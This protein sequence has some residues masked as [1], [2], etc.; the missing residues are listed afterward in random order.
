MAMF[1]TR[2]IAALKTSIEFLQKHIKIPDDKTLYFSEN[3]SFKLK[4][5]SIQMKVVEWKFRLL[6]IFIS[7]FQALVYTC[8]Q[9][10]V[11]NNY[12]FVKIF[13][14]CTA[15]EEINWRWRVPLAATIPSYLF[16][17]IHPSHSLRSLF[18]CFPPKNLNISPLS[19]NK[20]SRI[21][22]NN[23]QK[24]N[25]KNSQ[26]RAFIHWGDWKGVSEQKQTVQR[27]WTEVIE[28]AY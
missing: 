23:T 8:W 17:N 27:K 4:T 12:K 3:E 7:L 1:M 25:K 18:I 10:G 20:F 15:F 22:I 26:E 2:R 9:N 19:V 16:I 5:T 14:C 11:R 28:N 13:R 6:K 21:K 24:W